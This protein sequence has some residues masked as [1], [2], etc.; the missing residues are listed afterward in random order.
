MFCHTEEE[1]DSWLLALQEAAGDSIIV[2]KPEKPADDDPFNA[3]PPSAKKEKEFE[4]IGEAIKFAREGEKIIIYP[5][6]YK[7]SQERVRN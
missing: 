3:P 2:R 7:V 1:C 5:G 6:E 4:T